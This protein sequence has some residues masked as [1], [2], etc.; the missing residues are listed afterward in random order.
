[1]RVVVPR[2]GALAWAVDSSPERTLPAYVRAA[3]LLVLSMVVAFFS[4][5]LFQGVLTET[6]TKHIGRVLYIGTVVT[7][8]FLVM[9]R[10]VTV[11]SERRAWIALAIGL[12]LWSTADV[13]RSMNPTDL[14][15]AP[16]FSLADPFEV[17]GHIGIYVGVMLLVRERAG[18]FFRS[19]W[20]DG[21][22]AGLGFTALASA[23]AL[24][25]LTQSS[26][27]GDQLFSLGYPILD[28]TLL[29]LVIGIFATSGLRPSRI[30]WLLGASFAIRFSADMLY[31]AGRPGDVPELIALASLWMC[32]ITMLSLSAWQQGDALKP[33]RVD[34]W[35]V[36]VLPLVFAVSSLGLILTHVLLSLS[37]T[38][39]VLATA[40]VILAI[41]RTG[42]MFEEMSGIAHE[43]REVEIDALTGL[44]NR[45]LLN[46]RVADAV[47][48]NESGSVL[49]LIDLD[50][51]KEINEA[52]GYENGDRLLKLVGER[53]TGCLRTG[54]TLVRLGGDDFAILLPEADTSTSAAVVERINDQL[55]A[56]FTV[57][58][59]FVHVD[60]SVGVAL[61]PHHGRRAGDLLRNA[62]RA[63]YEAKSMD[64]LWR[65]YAQERDGASRERLDFIA[66]LRHA[67]ASDQLVLH[68]QPKVS[69]TDGTVG[70]A[71]A[72]VRWEHPRRGLLYPDAFIS[73]AEEARLMEALT[74]VVLRKALDQCGRWRALG[75]ELS[76][77]VNL[78]P[79]TLLKTG[80]TARV[81]EALES[82]GLPPSALELEIT[83]NA[84]LADPETAHNVVAA[85]RSHGVSVSVD[86]YGTG[87]ASLGYLRKLDIDRLKLDREL[88][89][90]LDVDPTSTAIIDSTFRL[91]DALHLRTVAEG[92]ESAHQ[93]QR[94]AELG[95]DEAQGYFLCR[96]IEPEAFLR[97]LVERPE[98]ADLL[99]PR[100]E[101][102]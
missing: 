60:V 90:D 3:R 54:D 98:R 1:L 19:Q 18:R 8:S 5:A 47:H 84:L 7:A 57:D 61:A 89:W 87:F 9:V 35:P 21:L 49:M 86:D 29:T 51:F 96:P 77:A 101:P 69:L 43:R 44:G 59:S 48:S 30:W 94:L 72:L 17:L 42:F 38:T 37:T 34:G 50:R 2:W 65:L 45:R 22:V 14:M 92:V 64:Q 100:A 4:L 102:A 99:R 56:P 36:V 16:R 58:G 12:S 83:E 79:S 6:T 33:I 15:S 11:G 68:Y 78:S 82:A 80:L 13:I 91:A 27:G 23:F 93:M 73:L 74:A 25:A 31:V 52:L 76:V 95:C 62:E 41:V 26:D 71:E 67:I 39:L 66:E 24:E 85:L 70:G 32:A 81:M 97:W 28:L 46:R 88:V 63:M 10:A 53:L 40:A 55:A 75:M 20:L